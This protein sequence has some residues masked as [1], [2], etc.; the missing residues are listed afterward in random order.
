MTEQSAEEAAAKKVEVIEPDAY[1]QMIN[2]RNAVRALATLQSQHVALKAKTAMNA[3]TPML[4][5]AIMDYVE[6]LEEAGNDMAR[7]FAIS[8]E[9]RNFGENAGMATTG[10][11][12]EVLCRY[13]DEMERLKK[14]IDQ[15]IVSLH[16]A[17]IARAARAED[18]DTGMGHTVAAELEALV[19]R[20]LGDAGNR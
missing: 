7:I 18:E 6:A 12:A 1:P 19:N 9:I 2:K 10:K 20:R 4:R 3:Y 8:H 16:I 14:P 13:M 15:T 17:T 11:V 5:D